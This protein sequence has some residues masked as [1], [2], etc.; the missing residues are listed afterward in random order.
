MAMDI[1]G[2]YKF[3]QILKDHIINQAHLLGL[4]P[5]L[6]QHKIKEFSERYKDAFSLIESLDDLKDYQNTVASIKNVFEEQLNKLLP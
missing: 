3:N 2:Q 1:G 5:K 4:S 6:V